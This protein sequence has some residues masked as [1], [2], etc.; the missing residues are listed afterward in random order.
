MITCHRCDHPFTGEVYARRTD[1][2]WE[3]VR[4][5]CDVPGCGRP[6]RALT[7]CHRHYKRHLKGHGITD[8]IRLTDTHLEDAEFMARHGETL[9]GAAKRLGVTVAALER[10]LQR[11]GRRDVL[12]VLRGRAEVAA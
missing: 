1:D 8:M 9:A 4:C 7:Y 10:H 3:H 12:A 2:G 11:H 5:P 6:R